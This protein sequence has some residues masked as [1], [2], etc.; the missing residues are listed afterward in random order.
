MYGNSA[1][2]SEIEHSNRTI[3]QRGKKRVKEGG[4]E[5]GINDTLQ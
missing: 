1:R 5:S 3:K 4:F 2:V